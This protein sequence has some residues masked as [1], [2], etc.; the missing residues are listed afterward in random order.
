[1]ELIDELIV[2]FL[3]SDYELSYVLDTKTKEIRL[4]A[5]ESQTG[6]PEIDWDDDEAVQYLVRIPQ[7]TTDEAYDLMVKFAEM[8]DSSIAV[9]LLDVLNGRKPFRSFKDKLGEQGIGDK[10]YEFENDYA[11]N[12]MLEWLEEVQLS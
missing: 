10:W 12:R 9:Q 1:M 2:V 8:Q 4:D 6:M 5:P 3:E 11:E 7:I